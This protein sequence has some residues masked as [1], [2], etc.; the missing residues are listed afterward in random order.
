L[1]VSQETNHILKQTPFKKKSSPASKRTRHYSTE[2]WAR[3]TDRSSIRGGREK[4]FFSFQ[5]SKP[6]P[7]PSSLCT[8]TFTRILKWPECEAEW[9]CTCILPICLYGLDRATLPGK[10]IIIIDSLHHTRHMW[11]LHP[12][13]NQN[14]IPTQMS[15]ELLFPLLSCL[16]PVSCLSLLLNS[17]CAFDSLQTRVLC[18][19]H[20]SICCQGCWGY[21]Q[22]LLFVSF[23]I[24]F[25]I[26]IVYPFCMRAS[27]AQSIQWQGYGPD[28][29]GIVIT[30]QAGQENFLFF[31]MSTPAH[32]V[33]H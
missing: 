13:T 25:D 14:I 23:Y 8:K 5:L 6:T 19:Q 33:Y 16:W 30:I 22:L 12:L 18:C 17:L 26:L 28:D 32:E 27:R 20:H 2:L 10:R 11:I 29:W 7:K 4:M 15:Y 31:T 9:S 24:F 3:P 1:S 21:Y